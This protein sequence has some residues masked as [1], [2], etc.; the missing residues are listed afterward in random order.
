MVRRTLSGDLAEAIVSLIKAEGLTPGAPLASLR[1][2]ADRFD[3]AVPTMRE[4][5]RQ[6]EGLGVV[7]FRH[8]SG[9][10]V[11]PNA[12]RRVLANPLQS[13]PDRDGL[14]EL[15]E[16]RRQIEPAIARLAAE[17]QDP[18]GLALVDEQLAL[19]KEQVDSGDERLALTNIDFHRA[20]AATSGNR[21]LAEILDSVML[22]RADDQKEILRLHGQAE[23]DYDEHARIAEWVRRG[24]ADAAYQAAYSHL[25][26]VLQVIRSMRS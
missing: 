12:G 11:G 5:M 3:V 17:V 25:D 26:H 20:L 7:E 23:D 21:V 1:S 10:Y 9:L 22:L 18:R 13:S 8:G 24:D 19:A 4:A 6:L 15:L 14:L 16:A 2:M